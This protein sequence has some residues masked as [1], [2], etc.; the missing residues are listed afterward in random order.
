MNVHDSERLA[1][2]LENAGYSPA[3]QGSVADVVVFNTRAV[4]ENADNKL[5]PAWRTW[6]R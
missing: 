2:M 1:G 4:R 3:A 5:Y 6:C